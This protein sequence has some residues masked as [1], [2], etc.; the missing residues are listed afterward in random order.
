MV[1]ILSLCILLAHC[2]ICAWEVVEVHDVGVEVVEESVFAEVAAIIQ[3]RA[4]RLFSRAHV[5]EEEVLI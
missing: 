1:D 5:K 2:I 4:I 3:V